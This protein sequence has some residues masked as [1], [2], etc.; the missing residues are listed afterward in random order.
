MREMGVMPRL[1]ILPV[2]RL[3]LG[4]RWLTV[5][6]RGQDVRQLQAL[7]S[8]LGLYAGAITW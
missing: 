7:L 3:P 8:A 5:G 1:K 4:K 2:S 6:A